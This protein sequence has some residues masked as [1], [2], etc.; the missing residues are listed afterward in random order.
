M[1]QTR[2]VDISNSNDTHTHTKPNIARISP[3]THTHN[4]VYILDVCNSDTHT[5]IDASQRL[6]SHRIDHVQ[7]ATSDFVAA[8]IVAFILS[9]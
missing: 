8:R 4:H 3:H 1:R 7:I 9:Q 2:P 6:L 5:L